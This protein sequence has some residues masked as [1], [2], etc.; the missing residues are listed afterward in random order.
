MKTM[1][2]ELPCGCSSWVDSA[3]AEA[4]F[5]TLHLQACLLG[6]HGE[7]LLAAARS[8]GLPVEEVDA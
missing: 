4:G 7:M 3:D 1:L 5:G 8:S 6:N 2:V